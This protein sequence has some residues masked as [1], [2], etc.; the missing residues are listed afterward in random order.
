MFGKYSSEKFSIQI[1]SSLGRDHWIGSSIRG[2][3][4]VGNVL[5]LGW[6]R[7]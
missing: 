2:M 7:G 4:V 6:V 1:N 3:F 5:D